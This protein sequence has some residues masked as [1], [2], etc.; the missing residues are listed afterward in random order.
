MYAPIIQTRVK[1]KKGFS[2]IAPL[3]KWTDWLFSEEIYNAE[4]KG[5][6]FKILKG[7]LFEKQ[8]IFKDFVNDIYKIKESY[9]KSHPLYLI[10]KLILNSLYGRYGMN[11]NIFFKN[12]SFYKILIFLI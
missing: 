6:S 12:T 2:T 7:Y 9:D 4:K 8:N 1:T 10:S 5:Y 3:G 11:C